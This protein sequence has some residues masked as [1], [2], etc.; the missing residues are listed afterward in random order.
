L[1]ELM[2]EIARLCGTVEQL[3]LSVEEEP[4]TDPAHPFAEAALGRA[5]TFDRE[6]A[7]ADGSTFVGAYLPL[8]VSSA[9][10]QV[11]VGSMGL[12]WSSP[13]T[14]DTAGQELLSAFASL[15]WTRQP[16]TAISTAP[17]SAHEAMGRT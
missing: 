3:A 8:I 5:A 13:H 7:M 9:G 2:D 10:V 12:G 15:A 4:V 6:A 11:V 14:V 16:Q 17:V 1:Q